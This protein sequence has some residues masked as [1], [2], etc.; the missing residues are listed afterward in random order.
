[1][2]QKSRN[3]QEILVFSGGKII[4]FTSKHQH[5]TENP[6]RFLQFPL[7]LAWGLPDSFSEVVNGLGIITHDEGVADVRIRIMKKIRR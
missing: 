3:L 6:L 4:V 1:M 5:W 2:H 7:D